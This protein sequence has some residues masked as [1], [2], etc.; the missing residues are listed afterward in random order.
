MSAEPLKITWKYVQE[1]NP[2][3]TLENMISIITVMLTYRKYE[4]LSHVWDEVL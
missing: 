3:Q 4:I 1:F 2:Y